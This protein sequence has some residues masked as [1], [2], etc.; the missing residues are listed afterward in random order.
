LEN[1][2]FHQ[3]GVV[4]LRQPPQKPALEKNVL[5]SKAAS[6]HNQPAEALAKAGSRLTIHVGD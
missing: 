4:V 2:W 5:A 3:S 1:S 6:I